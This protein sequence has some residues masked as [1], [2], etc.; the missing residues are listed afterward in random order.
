MQ[1]NKV[2]VMAYSCYGALLLPVV[3]LELLVY[4]NILVDSIHLSCPKCDSRLGRGVQPATVALSSAVVPAS[5]CFLS[6]LFRRH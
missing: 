2:H 3:L 6:S 5:W 1:T 4:I